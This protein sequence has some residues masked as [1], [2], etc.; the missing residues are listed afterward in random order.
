M[1]YLAW[2]VL[3]MVGYSTVTLMVKLATRT[4]DLNAFAVLAI[5]TSMVAVAAVLNAWLGGSFAGRRARTS[6]AGALYA[7]AAGTAL[8]VA[9][10]S[11][12]KGLSLGPASIVRAGLRHVHR[13]RR[14]PRRSGSRRTDDG[15]A[16]PGAAARDCGRAAGGDIEFIA[17]GRVRDPQNRSR[18]EPRRLPKDQFFLG[19]LDEADEHVL[20]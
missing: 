5:A 16:R 15:Q 19:D 20:A 2:A 17:T 9:V 11:L 1:H 7:Y 4:G 6:E 3:G 10:G 13:R 8:T 18:I 12:F 14:S